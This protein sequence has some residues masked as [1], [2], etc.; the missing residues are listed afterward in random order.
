MRQRSNSFT[1]SE[2]SGV[3]PLS[4]IPDATLKAPGVANFSSVASVSK[5]N[6]L[7]RSNSFTRDKPSGIVPIDQ[8]PVIESVNDAEISQSKSRNSSQASD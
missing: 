7:M 5:K 2:P 6:S 3:V 1:K 8:I 4:V